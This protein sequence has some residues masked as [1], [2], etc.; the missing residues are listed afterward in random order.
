MLSK[1]IVL[2]SAMDNQ[3]DFFKRIWIWSGSV[4]AVYV[5]TESGIKCNDAFYCSNRENGGGR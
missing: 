5:G 1:S 2:V 3:I 4:A